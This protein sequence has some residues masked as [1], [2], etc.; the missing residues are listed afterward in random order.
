ML[1][2]NSGNLLILF[3]LTFLPFLPLKAMNDGSRYAESSVL[4]DGKWVKLRVTENAVYKLTYDDIK[5]MGFNDPAKIKIYGYGGWILDEDFSKSYTDDLPEVSVFLNKGSDGTFNSGDYL[6]FYGR[7]TV[8][9]A[10]NSSRDVFEHEN[11]PYSTYGSYFITESDSGPK[12]MKTQSSVSNTDVTL[13]TFDDYRVH[14]RDSIYLLASGRELFGESFIN[15]SQTKN[16]YFDVPGITSDA[17]KARLSF[18]GAPRNQNVPVYLSVDDKE[19]LTLSIRYFT[20]TERKAWLE[21]GWADWSGDKTERVKVTVSYNSSGQAVANL[22]FIALNMK[23][24]LKFYN[25]NYTFFRSRESLKKSIKYVIENATSSY[26]VWDITGNYDVELLQTSLNG[27][28]LSFGAESSSSVKEYVMV[29]P[30]KTFPSPQVIGEIKNQN[31]HSLPQTEMVIIVPEVYLSYAEKLAEKHRTSSGLHVT[32]VQE[33]LIFNEFSSGVRDATAY[34]RLMKMFY[35]RAETDEEKPKYLLL[36]GDGI[37]DNRHLTSDAAKLDSKYYL[38]TYQVKESVY[39]STSYGTDDYFGFLDDDEGTSLAAA[40]LDVGIGRFPVSSVIQAENIVNK[41]IAY[42]ENSQYGNWKNRLVLTADNTDSRNVG[43]FCVHATQA[44]KLGKYVETNHPEYVVSKYYMDAYKST[45]VNGKTTYPDLKKAFF[46]TLKEGSFVVNYTGH[47]SATALSAEDLLEISDVRQMKFENLPLWITSTCDFAWFDAF[48][49]SAGEEMFLNKNSGGIA[50]ITT[51]RVVYSAN[52]DPLNQLLIKYLF[53]KKD[54]K[55]LRLGDIMKESKVELDKDENPLRRDYNKLNFILLGDPALMLNYPGYNVE[56]QAINGVSVDEADEVLFKALDRVTLEGIVTDANGNKIDG[57]NGTLR[58]S[59]F[60]SKQTIQSVESNTNGERFSYT[61]YPSMIYFGNSEISNGSFSVE[62]NVPLDISY[63]R[64][65]GKISFYAYDEESGS[66]AHGS[67]LDYYLA[68]TSD[69][70]SFN[71]EGPE[72]VE[73]FLNTKDFQD[74]DKVNETPYFYAFV[75]DEDGINM[76]GSGLGHDIMISIDD[77]PLYTYSLNSYYTP[78]NSTEGTIGF[79]IPA[80]PEGEHVLTF[81]VW[82]ILNNPSVDSLRFNVVKDYQPEIFDLNATTNPA[83]LN[84]SFVLTHDLPETELSIDIR[85]Y[86]LSGRAVWYYTETGSSGFLK[87]YPIEWN[88]RSNGGSRVQPGIYIY[89]AA[90]ST[91]SG[92][93]ATKAKKIIVLGQ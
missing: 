35:D 49:I 13:T 7:G 11:N 32:V 61:T 43:N 66:E 16:F 9:W 76:T 19:L 41:V 21:D 47:G 12:E 93:A 45:I 1:K 31:L 55:H 89:R 29:D 71:D 59:V 69:N 83:K 92:K 8:K 74:G 20:A 91:S 88:L 42:I 2:L 14:E 18:A 40:F 25:E 79:S 64:N 38:L 5:K 37:F 34:R 52:N 80:L 39:E 28:Q 85:V 44:D 36:F 46:N 67:F 58:T 56:L 60:D 3:L 22:N 48:N 57:F 15:S 51:T 24:T 72:I 62:F 33:D 63:E 78:I 77:N 82:D 30:G 86:D 84:T 50:L 17:G 23:R 54:G 27:S 4:S 70:P 65:N 68:G 26:M 6:L 90:I 73:M 87:N 10:Y 53:M 81:R 75:S